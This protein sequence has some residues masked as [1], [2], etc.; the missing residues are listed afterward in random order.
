MLTI[1]KANFLKFFQI[2]LCIFVISLASFAHA[3][4][5]MMGLSPEKIAEIEEKLAPVL[6]G[7]PVTDIP[8]ED[9]LLLFTAETLFPDS[10][11]LFFRHGEYLAKEKKDYTQAIPRLK[12]AL[13]IT[14]KDLDTLDLLANC[15][16]E[17]KK[18]ADAVSCWESLRER[19]DEDDSKETSK[20]RERVMVGLAR[21][22]EE[23]Q[24]VM[25]QGKK[26]I[27]YT[28]VSGEYVQAAEELTDG[29]LKEI[30]TQVTND[31]KCIPAFRTSIIALDPVKFEEIK[32]TS[33]AGGFALGGK[34]MIVP[35]EKF[36]RSD[37]QSILPAKPLLLHEFTHNIIFVAANGR[38]PTWLNEGLA[39]FEEHKND[40]YTEFQPKVQIPEPI[41]SID[42]LEKEFAEI[43]KITDKGSARVHNAYKLAGLSARFL[44]Q[45]YTMSAPIQ[46]L[47]G[48]KKKLSF[49][50]VLKQ[51]SK[52][53]LSTFDIAFKNWV[54]QLSN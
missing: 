6:K 21:M 45:N 10:F 13:E 46:I 14:P 11:D 39:V 50:T 25:R 35:A 42:E 34:S 16:F 32:P 7:G 2:I 20:L 29:R 33:W 9:R 37:P 23:N 54:H 36:P 26:F 53:D 43:K 1:R 49:E 24:M 47:N 18:D 38:C 40:T 52:F 3:E 31:L 44:I 17:L 27:V 15:Y 48:L 12:R 19:L 22:A 30:F 4:D 41:M 28:P 5:T 51:F 8:D